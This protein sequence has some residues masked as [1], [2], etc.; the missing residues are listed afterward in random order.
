HVHVDIDE[1]MV[2]DHRDR[3][4]LNNRLANLRVVSKSINQRNRRDIASRL[5]GV[6]RHRVGYSVHIASMYAAWTKDFFEA[7]CIR[8]SL[9]LQHG[10]IVM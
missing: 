10:Y 9:E 1:A 8:K 2:I 6:Y 7:C 5:C 4:G 3:D